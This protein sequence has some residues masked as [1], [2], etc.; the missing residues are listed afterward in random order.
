V[1]LTAPER[2]RQLILLIGVLTALS[3]LTTDLYLPAFPAMGHDLHTGQPAIQLTL[4]AYLIGSAIGM[5]V[6]GPI[7]DARGRIAPLRTSLALY[8]VLTLSC[9]VAPNVAALIA[10]RV[11]QGAIASTS[12]V[13]VRAIVRDLFQGV[14]VARFM[15]R[16]M[17]VVG[18]VPILAP[19]F[20]G[21][22]LRVT[23][24]RGIFVV[25]G[26]VG[27]LELAA[28]SRWLPETLP[29]ER[30]RRSG[31]GSSGAAYRMLSRD[32]AFVGTALT[33][34]FAFAA[35]LVYISVASF[36]FEHGYG[37][38]P[39][40]FGVI[41]GINAL[42]MVAFSQVN[43][44]LVG[45]VEPRRL[46]L[47]ALLVMSCGGVTLV[48]VAATR[49]GGIVGLMVPLSVM[50]SALGFITANTTAL[51]LQDHPEVAGT[52]SACIGC[53]QFVVGGL[54]APATGLWG[55]GSAV[56]MGVMMAGSTLV[57]LASFLLVYGNR[58]DRG[59]T[60]DLFEQAEALT[61]G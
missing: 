8:V 27:L 2:R 53:L 14:E 41:F 34:S 1:L 17:M 57:A 36:V 25:L 3:P 22:L 42:F 47:T 54:L 12:V 40:K 7:S 6:A 51:A 46:I 49:A 48:V 24:W 19:F 11:A 15:S 56:A 10:L 4:T 13:V 30:R 32:R 44:H 21:Q 45:K 60:P 52:A 59:F 20:G 18:F 43:A 28:M 16:L 35:V 50:L 37:L 33:S 29:P 26:V 39:Q 31:L 38:S 61:T 55:E 5:L 58:G 23:Q 9:A